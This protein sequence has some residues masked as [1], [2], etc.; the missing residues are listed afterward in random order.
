MINKHSP[1]PIYY[2]IEQSIKNLIDKGDLKPGDMIPSEREYAENYQISRMTVRQ[3]INN[4]VNDGYLIRQKGKG[5]F[6]A[7]QKIEQKL[8]GLTSFT[9]DMKARGHVPSTL[10]LD[11]K[12]IDATNE[13]AVNLNVQMGDALYEIKRIRL[14][15]GF[16]MALETNY[17]P[18]QLVHHLTEEVAKGSIYQFVEQRLGL[19]IDYATQELESSVARETESELLN[20]AK[21]APVLHIK[22]RTFLK[23]GCPLEFVHSIYRG[24]RYKFVI[25]M[26]RS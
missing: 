4:L 8:L 26:H 11:F 25:D 6:V 2:Q 23:N 10:L 14:A 9:E 1:V 18:V 7:S 12:K 19:E 15:D 21:G 16:P 3:A 17:M 22:R 5:T 24:D 20:I 13:L